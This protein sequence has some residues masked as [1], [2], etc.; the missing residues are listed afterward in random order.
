[1]TKRVYRICLFIAIL[2]FGCIGIVY[3]VNY[4]GGEKQKEDAVLVQY[5]IPETESGGLAA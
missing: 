1:M 3:Y 5:V 2:I 4:E